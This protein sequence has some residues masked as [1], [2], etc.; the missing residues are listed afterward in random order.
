[1]SLPRGTGESAEALRDQRQLAQGHSA[2]LVTRFRLTQGIYIVHLGQQGCFLQKQRQNALSPQTSEDQ[3]C[4]GSK[5]KRRGGR[6]EG[7]PTSLPS[8]PSVL[9]LE[10]DPGGHKQP[11]CIF[12]E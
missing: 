7:V 2:R 9:I 10:S 11:S 3:G 1:M 8:P 6:R 12:Q 5:R 4:V